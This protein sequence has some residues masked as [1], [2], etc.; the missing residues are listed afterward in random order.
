MDIEGLRAWLGRARAP[1]PLTLY[2]GVWLG[3]FVVV[4]SLAV[5][6][7]SLGEGPVLRLLPTAMGFVA[8]AAIAIGVRAYRPHPSRPW[9][10]LA[11]CL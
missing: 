4:I 11:T 6:T 2:P 10:L 1:A 7:L 5:I 9:L 3:Y 8:A